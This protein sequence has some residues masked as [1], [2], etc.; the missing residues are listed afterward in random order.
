MQRAD[1]EQ[2]T[3][4]HQL[5]AEL[6]PLDRAS[7]T[8]RTSRTSGRPTRPPVHST[9]PCL[10][11]FCLLPFSP[12]HTP[13]TFSALII[14]S[15]SVCLYKDL[16]K[17][18]LQPNTNTKV[19]PTGVRVPPLPPVPD[20]HPFNRYDN[21]DDDDTSRSAHGKVQRHR[22][23]HF[24]QHTH[25]H[26][27]MHHRCHTQRLADPLCTHCA[28]PVQPCRGRTHVLANQRRLGERGVCV[29]VGVVGGGG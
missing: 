17:C 7:R 9:A 16:H 21:D 4:R 13:H 19:K 5:S 22:S 20:P 3:C 8:S 18:T 14:M 27:H 6:E 1:P 26:T 25:T 29:W 24:R 12:L 23:S 10:H 2:V 15:P 28:A 11:P